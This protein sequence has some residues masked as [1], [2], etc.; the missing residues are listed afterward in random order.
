MLRMVAICSTAAAV[1][2]FAVGSS[3]PTLAQDAI[4]FGSGPDRVCNPV[5]DSRR[6]PVTSPTDDRHIVRQLG[7]YDCPEPEP[8]AAVPAPVV[9]PAA[10][11]LPASGV[12]FF[13]FDRSDLNA[14]AQ[15]TMDAIIADIRDRE[16]GGIV[17]GG[18]T[19]TAG[20]ADYN[21]EL[22]QRRAQTVAEELIRAGIP[23]RIVA[24]EAFGQTDLA[25]DTADEVPLAANRRAVIDFQR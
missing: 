5:V 17:I 4:F 14:E 15:A 18:H 7:T 11:P 23:A 16:L 9:A 22:S 19:D 3:S 25:V 24:T 1:L 8:V 21:M 12:V 2:A 20:S 6:E 10:P 13:D